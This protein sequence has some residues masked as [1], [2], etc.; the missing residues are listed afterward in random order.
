[1]YYF[2]TYFDSH[3]LL[4]GLALYDSLK[5]YCPSF[6]LWVL[7]LDA[8]CQRILSQLNLP[9]VRLISLEEFEK[10]DE[11]LLK[12]R[13]SRSLMEYYFT[14]TPSLPL[15]ILNNFPEVDHI[16]YLDADLFFFSDLA[17]IYQEIG[18]HSIAI[19]EH[20]FPFYLRDRERYGI[21]N[22]GWLSFRRDTHALTCLQWW[23]ERCIEWCYDRCEEGRYADQKYLDTW[24]DRFQNVVVLQHKGVNLAPWNLVNYRIQEHENRVWV[25]DQPL[26]F[27]HFHGF[28]QITS[29]LYDPNFADYDLKPSKVIRQSIYAPYIS[30]LLTIA[31]QVPF[32]SPK[33]SLRSNVRGQTVKSRL[34]QGVRKL[35]KMFQIGKG[36]LTQ[37]YILV[38]NGHA[39]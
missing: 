12:A 6:R 39:L 15:F 18:N 3:Y 38:I 16:T 37:R 30:S 23:R 33:A 13:Q 17:P 28:K 32:V 35:R 10:G 5:R 11:E 7:G 26:I 36:F 4:R 20:R 2:C 14:C 22:V 8:E 29:W 21:Y 1:M 25:D 19:V 34:P 9:D 27:F 31:Q 24:P